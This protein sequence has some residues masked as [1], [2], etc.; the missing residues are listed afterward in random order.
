MSTKEISLIQIT[1]QAHK[2]NKF[3]RMLHLLAS[4]D[5]DIRLFENIMLDVAF[6]EIVV[7][8]K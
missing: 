8:I 4:V 7:G 1:V 5:D 2:T 3:V 6:G